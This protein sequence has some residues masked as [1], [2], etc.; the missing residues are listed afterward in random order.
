MNIMHDKIY[1][2]R[3]I[4]FYTPQIKRSAAPAANAT[5]WSATCGSAV[6]LVTIIAVQQSALIGFYSREAR[7]AVR[8][9]L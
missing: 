4:K 8:S 7:R 6:N 1:T 3:I 5:T 2:W 9:S